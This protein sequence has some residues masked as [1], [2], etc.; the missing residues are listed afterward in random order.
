VLIT[1]FIALQEITSNLKEMLLLKKI[2][3]EQLERHIFYQATNK[4]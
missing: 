4:K 2:L 1:E 3:I